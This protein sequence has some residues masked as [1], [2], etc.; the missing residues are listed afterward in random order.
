MRFSIIDSALAI[1][2][3]GVGAIAILAL[4]LVVVTVVPDDEAGRFF[5]ALSFIY[6][7]SAVVR[8]GT[9]VFTIK[10]LAKKKIISRNR[11]ESYAA[12]RIVKLI[13]I[14]L[15]IFFVTYSILE[16]SYG[17]IFE[18]QTYIAILFHAL[19]FF[20]SFL[21]Q[22]KFHVKTSVFINSIAIPSIFCMFAYMANSINLPT[23][24][25]ISTII[26]FLV[27]CLLLG[28]NYLPSIFLKL[29]KKSLSLNIVDKAC[30][31]Y[32]LVSF[33]NILVQWLP[34]LIAG[35][36]LSYSDTAIFTVSQR[37]SMIVSFFLIAINSY[38]V[39]R[40]SS[41][42]KSNNDRAKLQKIVSK[43]SFLISTTSILMFLFINIVV[44]IEVYD[45]GLEE[46]YNDF[47]LSL[48]ILS[49]AQLAS[50]VF[51]SVGYLLQLNRMTKEYIYAIVSAL[52]IMLISIFILSFSQ[53]L[54]LLSFVSCIAFGVFTQN[55]LAWSILFRRRGINT[56][57]WSIK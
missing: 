27:S 32:W 47:K 10:F 42:S 21:I 9:D 36:L 31:Q 49:C 43:T 25:L 1:L 20:N 23:A 34:V 12:N 7:Y 29:N 13:L 14:Y 38:S 44:F 57:R 28:K 50:S 54:T 4:N 18:I 41:L 2:V 48:I 45:F 55:F 24:Y 53:K 56:L 51:G 15:V 6:I 37:T 19:S 8:H 33:L 39:S 17:Q 5:T 35:F 40:F 26:T 52:S 3:K 22:C 16:I 11:I 30:F 46:N